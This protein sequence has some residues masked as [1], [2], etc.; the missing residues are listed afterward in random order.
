M[1]LGQTIGLKRAYERLGRVGKS[2]GLPRRKGGI[3]AQEVERRKME[4]GA[5]PAHLHWPPTS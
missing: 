1:T 2:E 4:K 5:L 3:E